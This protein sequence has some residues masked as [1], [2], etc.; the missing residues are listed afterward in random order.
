MVLAVLSQSV[1]LLEHGGW[2]A[3]YV[4]WWRPIHLVRGQL[5][6]W[7]VDTHPENRFVVSLVRN[8]QWVAWSGLSRYRAGSGVMKGDLIVQSEPIS[9]N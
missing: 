3:L 4:W 8:V 6:L 7:G 1:G 9:H 2:W 5:S